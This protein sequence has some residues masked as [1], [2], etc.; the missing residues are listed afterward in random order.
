MGITKF[1]SLCFFVEGQNFKQETN[2]AVG[3]GKNGL[4]GKCCCFDR[5]MGLVRTEGNDP[6]NLITVV[7]IMLIYYMVFHP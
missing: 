4:T 6:K 5:F 1:V 2:Y 7:K 3:N